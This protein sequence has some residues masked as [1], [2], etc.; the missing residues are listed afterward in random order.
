MKRFLSGSLLA[1]SLF[2]LAPAVSAQ[3]SEESAEEQTP[4]NSRSAEFR[5]VDGSVE[6]D[7]PGGPLLIGAYMAAFAL[8][9]GFVWRLGS[10]HQKNQRELEALRREFNAQSDA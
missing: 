4:E 5:A 1:L 8:M 2:A 7:V 10:L 6:E 3:D 9:L